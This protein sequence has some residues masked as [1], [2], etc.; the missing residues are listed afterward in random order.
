MRL[1]SGMNTRVLT[2]RISKHPT[3]KLPRI[4]RVASVSYLNA[5]PLIEGLNEAENVRLSLAVPSKLL[6]ALRAGDADVALLPVIDYQRLP[7]LRIIRAGAIGCDGPT[8]TVRIF[9]QRPIEKIERLA[10]DPDSHTSVALARIILAEQYGIRP[11][12]LDLS[13]P[14]GQC[15]DA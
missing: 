12:F 3:E 8:L 13:T 2:D 10:C 14:A 15:C 6:D 5:R 1:A 7:R 9:S 11:E 4:L